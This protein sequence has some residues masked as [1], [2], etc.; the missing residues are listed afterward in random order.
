MF[1]LLLALMIAALVT[2]PAAAQL[3]VTGRASVAI[4]EAANQEGAGFGLSAA[5]EHRIGPFGLVAELGG[6]ALGTPGQTCTLGV[7]GDCFPESS[8]R[9]VY[10]AGAALVARPAARVGFRG[11]ASFVRRHTTGLALHGAASVSLG[12]AQR[13]GLELRHQRF[14]SEPEGWL[15]ALG[16]TYR[17]GDRN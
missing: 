5:V 3:R 11:G 14:R 2:V 17:I 10:E 7:P 9:R 4:Y 12:R 1:K 13:L 15:T 8:P 16:L 6:Y